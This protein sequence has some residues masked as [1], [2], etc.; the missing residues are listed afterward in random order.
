MEIGTKIALVAL[1]ITIL[2][3]VISI[4]MYSSKQ[5]TAL[6]VLKISFEDFKKGMEK[7]FEDFKAEMKE[8]IRESRHHTD[9]HIKRLEEKQDKHNSVIERMAIV[10]QSVK[11]AHHRNDDVIIRLQNLE[12][13]IK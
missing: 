7:N 13:K 5:T 9:E 10:E 4:V 2:S 6:E 11:S 8:K 1:G 3:N 12:R